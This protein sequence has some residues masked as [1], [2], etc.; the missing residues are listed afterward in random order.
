MAEARALADLPPSVVRSRLRSGDLLLRTGPFTFRLRSPHADLA[1]NLQVLYGG[2]EELPAGTPV[3]FDLEIAD[4][5]FWRR[6]WRR[7]CRCVFDG[8]AVFEPL[9]AAHAYALLEW[10]MNWCISSHAHQYLIVHAAVLAREDRALILPA[11][12]G[13]GKSTLCAAL[14]HSGWRLLSDEL[15]LIDMRDGRIWPLC[16]PVSLK[17]ASIPVMRQFAPQAVFGE[18]TRD[19]TKGDVVHMA[20]PADHL[21]KMQQPARARWIVYP[22]YEAGADTQLV[23]RPR[24]PAVL[25]LARNAFNFH[26]QGNAGFELLCDVVDGCECFDF[27]YSRLPEA[28]ACFNTLA[29]ATPGA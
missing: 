27:R 21:R 26:F 16:R 23:A 10:S 24:A 28:M 4:G 20:V 18:V 5:A 17:N 19:T 3:D 9:P 25:D 29:G 13:S 1:R 8:R 15:T 2:C 7:Q 6:F 22:R 11:P 12:P 14:T